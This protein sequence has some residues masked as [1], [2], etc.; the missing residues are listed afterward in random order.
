V[1][2]GAYTD[3]LP[4]LMKGYRAVA[5]WCEELPGIP[6]NWH[7]T[8]DVLENVRPTDLERA[9]TVVRAILEK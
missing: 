7:W 8:T 1:P 3:A 5:L 2:P 6:P 4:F 9:K